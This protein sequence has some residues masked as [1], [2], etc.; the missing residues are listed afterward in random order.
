MST[1]DF[2][3][4]SVP[5]HKHKNGGGWIADTIDVSEEIYVGENARISGGA[6]SGGEIYGSARISGGEIYGG[7]IYGGEIYGSARI[8]GS[9]RI[10]G[11]EIYG[12]E[13]SGG[14]ISGGVISKTPL[15][16]QGSRD[17]LIVISNE[18][19]SIGCQCHSLEYW[20]EKDIPII[21]NYQHQEY[22]NDDKNAGH[23]AVLYGYD[24]NWFYIADPSNYYEDDG[25]KFAANKKIE[26][27]SYLI[28]QPFSSDN[29]S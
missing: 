1:F 15:Q 11:G 23:Y 13:I 18:F 26:R 17:F 2:G 14:V 3:F 5:A 22:S 8:S 27:S 10:Y 19:I 29:C 7:E 12:G 25:K 24:D 9:A 6:I 16:I 4:G 28:S 20:L 21:V